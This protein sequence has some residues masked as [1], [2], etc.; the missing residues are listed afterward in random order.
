VGVLVAGEGGQ[1]LGGQ[2]GQRAVAG[3]GTQAV[4]QERAP[5]RAGAVLD[6]VG[7]VQ[8]AR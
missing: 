5:D 8:D 4:V 7:A 3:D 1:R 2:V 6:L